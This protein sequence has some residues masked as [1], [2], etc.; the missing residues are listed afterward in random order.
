MEGLT[1]TKDDGDED[2]EDYPEYPVSDFEN[3]LFGDDYTDESP[4]G[5]EVYGSMRQYYED[6][7]RQ[8]GTDT[9]PYTINGSVVNQVLEDDSNIP[10]WVTLGDTKSSFDSIEGRTKKQARKIFRDAVLA[11][12][13]SQQGIDTTTTATRKI[14]IIYAGNR[15]SGGVLN[16]HYSKNLYIMS[17]KLSSPTGAEHNSDKFSHIGVHCHEF[18]HVLRMADYYGDTTYLQWGLM[19]NGGHKGWGAYPAPLSPHLRSNMGWLT[20]IEVTDLEETE[21]LSYSSFRDDVYRIRSSNDRTD[22]FLIENRQLDEKWNK[23]LYSGLLIW[24]IKDEVGNG[25][26]LIDLI[27]ADNIADARN[28]S[29]DPFPGSTEN[30]SLTD[31]T[32][33]SSREFPPEPELE[34]EPP[35]E[36]IEPTIGENSNV[37]VTNISDSGMEMTANLSPFWVGTIAENTTWSG[38]VRVGGD[39]TV[40]TNVTL[41]IEANSTIQFLADTDAAA[42]GTDTGRSELIVQGTLTASAGGITFRS[43]NADATDADWYG[44]RVES[45]GS[46]D[47]SNASLSDGVLCV[48]NTGGSVTLNGT[49]FDNCGIRIRILT[50]IRIRRWRRPLSH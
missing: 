32:T 18:G 22:F 7:S 12:A 49:S 24:H 9:T 33:P 11:A 43:T 20:P 10:V 38:T 36:P 40:P 25:V 48:S 16:P 29:G 28:Y 19:A 47:L 8:R 34:L 44:I 35:L 27:E 50:E 2:T 6:M 17:E 13:E 37:L 15:Y 45:M 30:R 4:D 14:C 46:A 21:T 31:F 41:T 3:M 39:V 26:D 23:G 5:D 42:G 1:G